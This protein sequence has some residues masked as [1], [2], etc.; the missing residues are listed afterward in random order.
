MSMCH[1]INSDLTLKGKM[2]PWLVKAL[3]GRENVIL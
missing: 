3:R 2:N 1:N